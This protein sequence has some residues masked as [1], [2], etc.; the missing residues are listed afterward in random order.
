M[1]GFKIQNPINADPNQL[2]KN[3]FAFVLILGVKLIYVSISS[4]SASVYGEIL[5]LIIAHIHLNSL[6]IY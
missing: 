6:K 2:K 3:I 5:I 4:V 1:V